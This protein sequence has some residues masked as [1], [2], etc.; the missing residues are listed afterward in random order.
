MAEH[1]TTQYALDVVS[2]KILAGPIVRG[3]C[4]RHLDDLENGAARGLRFDEDRANHALNFFPAVLRL[5]GGDFEGEPFNL[6]G[7]QQFI[8]GSLFGW[9]NSDGY[10]RFRIAY[11]EMGK[12][13]GKALAVDTPI[14]TPSGWKMMGDLRPLDALFDENGRI[15]RVLA[16]SEVMHNRPCYEVKFDDGETII[17]DE[18]HLWKTEMRS[19]STT[20]KRYSPKGIKRGHLPE[21][22]NAVRTTKDICETLT[23]KNGKYQSANHSIN[24]AFPLECHAGRFPIAPYI[25][26][27]WLGDGDSDCAR[28]TIGDSDVE[29]VS[30]LNS[31][32]GNLVRQNN[33]QNNT[34][35]YSIQNGL[36]VSLREFGLLN[37]KHIPS[38]YLRGSVE[39]RIDLMRGL[40]DTDGY[41]SDNGQC[42]F[43]SINNKLAKD[44][45]ELAVSLGIKCTLNTGRATIKGRHISDKYRVMFQA[46]EFKV[47]NLTRKRA[48]QYQRHDRRKLSADRRIVSCRRVDSVPVMCIQV[49]SKS[50]LFLAGRG[51]VPTHNSPLLA[52]IG[53]YG[54]IGDKEPRAEIYSA[55]SKKEQAMIMFRD[56]V[57]MVDLSVPLSKRF[58]KSG[59]DDKVWNLFDPVTNSFFRPIS[60]EQGQS[61]PRPHIGL[62]DELHEHKSPV[63][64]NMMAAGR[65]SRKQP[66]IVAITNS[67]FDKTSVCW[68]YHQKAQNVCVAGH[69]DDTFFSYVCALDEGE[70]PLKDEKCWIKA[71]PLLGV[72]IT[73]Q[74][75]RD[76]VV[77]ALSMPS[78]ESMVRRLNFCQWTQAENPLIPGDLWQKAARTFDL[79][80]FQG[81]EC[82]LGLDLSAVGDLTAAV[83]VFRKDKR[84]WWWPEFWI[85]ADRIKEK[86]DKDKVPYDVW[87]RKGF[88]RTVPGKSIN[89]DFVANDLKR[90]IKDNKLKISECAYDRWKIEDFKAASDR[91]DLRLEMTEFGQGFKDMGPAVDSIEKDLS[92]GRIIHNG[93]PVLDWCAANA[94]VSSD[95]AGS[96]KFDKSK[97]KGKRI[98]GIVAAAMAHHR[99]SL[100]P[101]VPPEL[102]IRWA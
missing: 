33:H 24:L 8:I 34:H 62:V 74:Y 87:L 21:W 46:P 37:N 70:D 12:G 89:L 30:I 36:Q 17:A 77:A 44:F 42:E 90:I 86:V 11:I 71:N 80:M 28:I 48:R 76:E 40:M 25:L 97:V 61:G 64:M 5:S 68:E 91:V 92:E 100:L 20:W 39:Q 16:T 14:P 27:A 35:R 51:M 82:I 19:I 66:L 67:G 32:G 55:A 95:P 26:G 54:I 81:S 9:L 84:F 60:A 102:R 13:N 1:P 93:S 41:I 72:T 3:A 22:R 50:N 78:K 23:Y 85:P 83:F 4:R 6:D 43:C 63:V 18:N 94:V 52:G 88:V 73:E 7:P 2:G 57:S 65:K 31:H 47:F 75:L 58:K 10:R 101:D 38:E 59:R 96:R 15:C 29:L 56:A 49:D 99:A 98:D 69:V 53:L 45:M 79:H